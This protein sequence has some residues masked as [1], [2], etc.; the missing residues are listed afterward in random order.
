[1]LEGQTSLPERSPVE[2]AV[3]GRDGLKG[4]APALFTR[5]SERCRC[6][7]AEL[8]DVRGAPDGNGESC[9]G[10]RSGR[11]RSREREDE[12]RAA[13]TISR[14]DDATRLP[15]RPRAHFTSDPLSLL[16]R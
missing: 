1:M 14:R 4:K 2:V 3:A 8:S 10:G 12:L 6:S 9:R 7:G 16:I 15:A 5:S 13:R 11:T